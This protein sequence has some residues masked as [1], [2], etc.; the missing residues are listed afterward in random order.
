M[1]LAIVTTH[2]IQYYAP[3]FM[4]LAKEPG[5]ELKV[6]YTWSQTRQGPKYDQDFGKM[7]EWDI[8]LLDG[9][10]YE[11][12]ENTAP[13]P[14]VHHFNG[15]VNPNLQNKIREWKPGFLLVIGWNF[16]SHLSALRHFKGKIPVLFRGDSTLLDEKPGPKRI[17]RRI[18]LKWVYSHVDYALY[19]GKNNHD[20]FL[21][22]GLKESQLYWVP[23]SIDNNRFSVPDNLDLESGQWRRELGV[24]EDDLVVLFAGK[25]ESKKDP[26]FMIRLA[27]NLI[28]PKL[29]L[30]IVGNGKLE[31]ELKA[32]G[33]KDKRIIFLDFQNQQKMPL[34]YRL[35]DI[36]V[37]PSI[38]PG[39]T[40]GL[41]VNE[42]MACKR[43]VIVSDKTGCAPDLVEENGTGWVF[44]PG[45]KG[46]L[47]IKSVLL[48]ILNNRS[49]LG[50]M[51]LQAWWKLQPYSYPTAIEKIRLLL[52]N[53]GFATKNNVL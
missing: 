15:I 3:L 19:A 13:D 6:F 25:L 2:P 24:V 12:I 40:W 7:I 41:A 11:F 5:I 14:G 18:F 43:P 52:E 21:K 42:A 31:K 8:P 37:L 50:S 49:V 27:Q 16:R 28:D 30:I 51:G 45:E 20:Y 17:L 26:D 36:F 10:L 1:R 48:K 22:H 39:E 23:H 4:L 44:E 46:D 9:Y 32:K 35:C 29:K 47:K 34:V 33:S 38:G 53:I